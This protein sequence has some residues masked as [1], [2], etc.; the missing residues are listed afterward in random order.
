M[1]DTRTPLDATQYTQTR[2]TFESN[3]S[4]ETFEKMFRLKGTRSGL[5]QKFTEI[6]HKLAPSFNAIHQASKE[7]RL[8]K[9]D[10]KLCEVGCYIKTVKES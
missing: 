4:I 5:K 10:G 1:R 8:V 3:G 9:I 7:D 2:S 6:E